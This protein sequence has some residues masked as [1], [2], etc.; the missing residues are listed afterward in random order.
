M[1]KRSTPPS[2]CAA[3]DAAWEEFGDN[4]S[5]EFL[6]SIT[7]DRLGIEYSDV[8]DALAERHAAAPDDGRCK[9]C[10]GLKAARNPTGACDHLYWPDYLTPEAKRA[11]GYAP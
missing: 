3:F 2:I 7:A 10:G 8:V 9:N 5:T 4:K 6:L 11:N 1:A